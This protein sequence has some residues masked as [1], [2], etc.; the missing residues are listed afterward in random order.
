[1]E[2]NFQE[3][4]LEHRNNVISRN[5]PYSKIL[6]LIAVF[7]IYGGMSPSLANDPG[8]TNQY[9]V[10]DGFIIYLGIIPAELIDGPASKT[11]HGGI[12]SGTFRYHVALAVFNK[13]NGERIVNAS[14]KVKFSNS[15]GETDFIELEPMS[16]NGKVVFGNYFAPTIPGPYRI[17]VNLRIPGRGSPVET[18]FQYQIGHASL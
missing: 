17:H 9:R 8:L 15:A 11:M 2:A 6:F 3:Y 4:S 7:F 1:M 14:L 13:E 18:E 5:C 10:I 16:F 12:P